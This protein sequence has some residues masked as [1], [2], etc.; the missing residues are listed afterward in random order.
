MSDHKRYME[1]PLVT[2]GGQA[3]P[4][5]HGLRR[6]V[7]NRQVT[8]SSDELRTDPP[9]GTEHEPS[10]NF[11]VQAPTQN[12]PTE[13]GSIVRRGARGETKNKPHA[14]VMVY[15]ATKCGWGQKA[16]A[17]SNFTASRTPEKPSFADIVEQWPQVLVQTA[18]RPAPVQQFIFLSSAV[19][20]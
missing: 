1:L 4:L 13:S 9:T 14:T 8:I 6:R 15:Y 7:A 12:F 16:A 19:C 2:A 3:T 10:N 18:P 17:N 20:H 11:P 5:F